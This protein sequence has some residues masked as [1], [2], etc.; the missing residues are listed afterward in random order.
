MK[1]MV[2][3]VTAALLAGCAPGTRFQCV[4]G[5]CLT[6]AQATD[7]CLAAAKGN[8]F[9]AKRTVW[10]WCMRDEGIIEKMCTST[11]RD[12]PDCKLWRVF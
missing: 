8:Y 1:T 7:K 2:L 11:E 3:L 5:A 10:R 9:G 12:N 4:T 6:Q